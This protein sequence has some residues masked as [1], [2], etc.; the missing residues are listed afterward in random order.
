MLRQRSSSASSRMDRQTNRRGS[1]LTAPH[2]PPSGG[3]GS[4]DSY[5]LVMWSLAV[6]VSVCCILLAII[7][8]VVTV[9]VII[10][11]LGCIFD[12]SDDY[13]PSPESERE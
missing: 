5:D 1:Q 4:M 6:S 10:G 9:A 8:I 3:E 11:I 2:A 7:G 12:K 13:H